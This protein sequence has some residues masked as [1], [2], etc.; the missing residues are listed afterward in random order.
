[1]PHWPRGLSED[2]AAAYVGLSSS[3]FRREV[4]AGRAPASVRL[5][6]G[7]QVWLREDLDAWLD[8]LAGR[9]PASAGTN[10][11]MAR[12]NVAG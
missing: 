12:V 1:M 4:G 6:P 2:L 5:T 9:A 8:R 7:R 11:W 3:T 10:P